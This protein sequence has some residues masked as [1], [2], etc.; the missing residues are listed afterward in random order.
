MTVQEQLAAIQAALDGAST[1]IESANAS[2]Q[3]I[4]ADEAAQTKMIQDLQAQVAAGGA[5]TAES[6][7]PLVDSAVRQQ[8]ATE[9][10]ASA[11]QAAADA[12]PDAPTA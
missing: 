5:V 11:M 7:Q 8:A 1:A 9:G 3:N 12:I 10:L 2:L 4:A 6:L